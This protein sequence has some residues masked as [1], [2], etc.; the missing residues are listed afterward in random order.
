MKVSFPMRGTNF[1]LAILAQSAKP[2]Q[3]YCLR[4]IHPQITP[5]GADLRGGRAGRSAEEK[6]KEM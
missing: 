3:L 4:I 2:L 1:F 6:D 5:I